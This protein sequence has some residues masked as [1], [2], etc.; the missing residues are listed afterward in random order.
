M[1]V[2]LV[3]CI[4]VNEECAWVRPDDITGC[5][6]FAFSIHTKAAAVHRQYVACQY[7]FFV[8]LAIKTQLLHA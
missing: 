4:I 2:Y 1:S 8:L 6:L 7:W 3:A 5:H